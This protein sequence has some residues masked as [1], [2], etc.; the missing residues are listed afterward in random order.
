MSVSADNMVGQIL[1]SRDIVTD[2]MTE[3][4]NEDIAIAELEK[5]RAENLESRTPM[6]QSVE[7]KIM[8]EKITEGIGN[9]ANAEISDREPLHNVQNNRE[10][11]LKIYTGNNA[12]KEILKM[13]EPNL[14]QLSNVIYAAVKLLREECTSTKRRKDSRSKKPLWKEN[15]KRD[16]TYARR[17][18][19]HK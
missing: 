15:R 1:Q 13:S 2:E 5:D 19:Y 12:L 11:Q 9:N 4:D 10:N 17:I 6:V 3:T 8:K 7:I 16:R 14:M 18:I